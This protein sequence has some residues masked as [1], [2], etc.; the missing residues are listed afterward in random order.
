MSPSERSDGASSIMVERPL[1]ILE[2]CDDTKATRIGTG[3]PAPIAPKTVSGT[4]MPYGIIAPPQGQTDDFPFLAVRATH[5]RHTGRRGPFFRES[6]LFH[7]ICQ[8]QRYAEKHLH[9]GFLLR[10]RP[11]R[12]PLDFG[13]R[14]RT[15][16]LPKRN[17]RAD[18]HQRP[19]GGFAL[20]CRVQ[21]NAER[22]RS[23]PS[24]AGGVIVVIVHE[25][26]LLG[27]TRRKAQAP[28]KDQPGRCRTKPRS[29]PPSAGGAAQSRQARHD[30]AAIGASL[31]NLRALSG[32][33]RERRRQSVGQRAARHRAGA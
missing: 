29:W 21:Y 17:L 12:Q 3:L 19:S 25:G 11:L 31:R 4:P 32:A 28:R 2:I 9:F 22:R 5:P 15:Q 18:L 23:P 24:V 30:A 10:I 27:Q 13:R 7:W 14:Q 20:T 8:I 33:D 26:A 6:S 16:L 1:L